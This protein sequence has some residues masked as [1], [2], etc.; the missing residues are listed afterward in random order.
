[1]H[2]YHKQSYDFPIAV[3]LSSREEGVSATVTRAHHVDL[4]RTIIDY[5]GIEPEI[6]LDGRQIVAHL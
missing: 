2:G 6:E 4:C 1:M 3:V 5:L